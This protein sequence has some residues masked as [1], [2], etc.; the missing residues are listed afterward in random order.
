MF[1][2]FHP[3]TI[4]LKG[5]P[6]PPLTVSVK[7]CA[8]GSIDTAQVVAGSGS[9]LYPVMTTTLLEVIP[10]AGNVAVVPE[11]LLEAT[12]TPGEGT[13]VPASCVP[14]CLNRAFASSEAKS[15]APKEG[16]R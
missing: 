15:V 13:F 14:S 7:V 16:E 10:G 3:S 12:A 6:L 9:A 4:Q 8:V 1:K 2:P 5:C 11:K